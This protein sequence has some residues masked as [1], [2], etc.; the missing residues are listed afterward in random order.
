MLILAGVACTATAF[1][2]LERA[3]NLAQRNALLVHA[4]AFTLAAPLFAFAL[5]FG[6]ASSSFATFPAFTLTAAFTTFRSLA[7]VHAVRL[8]INSRTTLSIAM[9]G[10]STISADLA[11]ASLSL[12][13]G[14]GFSLGI[15]PFPVRRK[16]V[17]GSSVQGLL[18]LSGKP[19][20]SGG[21]IL[22]SLLGGKIPSDL[23]VQ[24]FVAL[25]GTG[26]RSQLVSFPNTD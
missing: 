12:S 3:G 25:L 19:F 26:V 9:I 24:P 23:H 10:L 17:L 5:S 2:E 15:G 14:F 21:N 4:L 20:A 16:G 11:A 7:L 1:S 6:L 8:V 13:F 22:F 18:E